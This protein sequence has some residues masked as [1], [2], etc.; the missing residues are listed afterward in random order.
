M[1]K[2]KEPQFSFDAESGRTTCTLTDGT[3]FFIGEAYCCEKDRDMMSEKTGCAIA[4]MRAEIKYYIHMR[5]NEILPA[6]KAMKHLYA[7]I[8]NSKKFNEFAYENVMIRRQI[9]HLTTDLTVVRQMLNDEKQELKTLLREKDLFYKRV[10]A[11]RSTK[12]DPVG[13]N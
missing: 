13:Q 12:A 4:L 8:S 2:C 7:C 10:R 1:A 11:N 9:Q 6:L 3:N 5:D